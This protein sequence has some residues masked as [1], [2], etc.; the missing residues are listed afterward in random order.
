[1]LSTVY[2]VPSIPQVIMEVSSII[3]DPKTSAN[4][5]GRMISHDQG[6]VTKI[7]TVANS[8]L[9]GIPRRVSTIDFAIVVL[10]F[11]QVKNIVLALSMMD[12]LKITGDSKF[13]QKQYWLHSILTAAASKKIADDLGYQASGEVF[14]A[15]LLHDLGIAIINKFFTK[16]F[17]EILES[18]KKQNLTYL[19][20]EELHLGITHQEIGRYLVDRWNLPVAIADVINFHHKPSLAENNKELTALVHLADYMTKQLMIGDFS[21]DNTATLDP[22]I[23]EILRLGDSEY[24][25]N[26]IFSYKELFQDQIDS[27]NL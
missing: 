20:A 6:L 4:I 1:M 13:D 22:A 12:S 10:G 17:K 19:E 25:E 11:N 7:L 2:N 15:G 21:W 16:E 8:P 26:F 27:I 14:T 3:D 5:L 18:V 23:I 24:L 9:H